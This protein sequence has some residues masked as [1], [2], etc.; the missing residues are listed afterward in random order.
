MLQV[1]R[2]TSRRSYHHA[3]TSSILQGL[4]Q[5]SS[6]S[7]GSH[8]SSSATFL[9][10][11]IAPTLLR[12]AQRQYHGGLGNSR[13]ARNAIS[14]QQL[15]Y[16]ST[17]TSTTTRRSPPSVDGES[18][19]DNKQAGVPGYGT[20]SGI[21][22][23]RPTTSSSG[24]SGNNAV[25]SS[26]K[27]AAEATNSVTSSSATS[28]KAPTSA[29]AS[30]S[31]EKSVTSSSSGNKTK[32]PLATRVWAKVK[33]EAS[34]YWSGTKLL[35]K[36]IRISARLQWKLLK[37]KSLTRREKRQVSANRPIRVAPYYAYMAASQRAN[38]S[39]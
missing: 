1:A 22:T 32:A 9:A 28:A 12:G 35:G 23:P 33:S 38:E 11:F 37:G 7:S 26:Q 10:P 30:S 25:S 15:R 4:H 8:A 27:P 34:H 39:C 19:A 16:Q 21:A 2:S 31:S 24:S 17:E 29:S 5:S 6:S 14:L 36:E 18:N 13:L 3:P 20:V